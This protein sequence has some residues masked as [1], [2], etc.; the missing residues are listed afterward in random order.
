MKAPNQW[1]DLQK[2]VVKGKRVSEKEDVKNGKESDQGMEN[3]DE[4]RMED[5]HTKGC[6]GRE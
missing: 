6:G 1:Q 2:R 3:D 5:R 4:K